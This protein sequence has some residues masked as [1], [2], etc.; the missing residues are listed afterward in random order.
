MTVDD[1]SCFRQMVAFT[2]SSAGYGVMEAKDG[3]DAITQLDGTKLD[4][5]FVDVNMPE[6]SGI[7][8]VQ[9]VRANPLYKFIPII[10]LTS[11]S[12]TSKKLEGKS[13]G[14][15]GWI[16]KPFKPEQLVSIVKKIV[17]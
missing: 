5:M 3:T 8:L 6:M 12:G 17:G 10:M 16:V 13:A 15:T 1:S 14:A 9:T 2:L 4:M 7:E 11:E